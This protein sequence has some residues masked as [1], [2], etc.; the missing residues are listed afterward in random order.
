MTTNEGGGSCAGEGSNAVNADS[1]S[2]HCWLSAP[3]AAA[4]CSLQTAGG[5]EPHVRLRLETNIIIL[6]LIDLLAD[7]EEG[8][9]GTVQCV[10]FLPQLKRG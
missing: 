8:K 7:L 2:L 1:P 10:S 3:T 6:I 4:G 5:L 9:P